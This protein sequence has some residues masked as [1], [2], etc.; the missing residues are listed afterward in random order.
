MKVFTEI[1]PSVFPNGFRIQRFGG[2]RLRGEKVSASGDDL[3]L[4][5]AG[6]KD[7][8]VFPLLKKL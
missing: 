6:E 4:L 2:A 1:K 7:S 8:T 3:T 5:E